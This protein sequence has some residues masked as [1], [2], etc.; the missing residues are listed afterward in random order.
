MLYRYCQQSQHM[1]KMSSFG[2]NTSSETL[3]PLT[4]CVV[5]H[6]LLPAL[7]NVNQALLQLVHGVFFLLIHP[8]FNPPPGSDS[9]PVLDR[10]ILA[11][12]FPPIKPR[13]F[14]RSG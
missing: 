10:V 13:S 12:T 6:R 14:I 8:F 4:Y 1:L 5:K 9:R 7:P 2:A 11:P 3:A